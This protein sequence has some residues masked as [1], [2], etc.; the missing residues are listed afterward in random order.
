MDYVSRREFMSRLDASKSG[1]YTPV[2][3]APSTSQ[4]GPILTR[5][6]PS[7]DPPLEPMPTV[8]DY[9]GPFGVTVKPQRKNVADS[10]NQLSVPL[11]SFNNRGGP[12]VC[13]GFEAHRR[14]QDVTQ[15]AICSLKSGDGSLFASTKCSTKKG[16][17]PGTF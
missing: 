6:V 2:K 17:K 12:P 10:P 14:K 13:G 7:P 16:W 11:E 5:S 9:R 4:Q 8:A 15:H 1:D 3:Y